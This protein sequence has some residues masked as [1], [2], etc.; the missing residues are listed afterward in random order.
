MEALAYLGLYLFYVFFAF[1]PQ[2][3]TIFLLRV[4]WKIKEKTLVSI[5]N[6]IVVIVILSPLF[7]LNWWRLLEWWG[8][9]HMIFIVITLMLVIPDIIRCFK[10]KK[11]GEAV[12]SSDINRIIIASLFIIVLMIVSFHTAKIDHFHLQEKI[13]RQQQNSQ[14]YNTALVNPAQQSNS[15]SSLTGIEYST[16]CEYFTLQQTLKNSNISND[17]YN[18]F[19]T[20]YWITITPDNIAQYGKTIQWINPKTMEVLW[21]N[22]FSHIKDQGKIYSLKANGFLIDIDVDSFEFLTGN[23][24]YAKDKN[25]IYYFSPQKELNYRMVPTHLDVDTFELITWSNAMFA[26]DKNNIYYLNRRDYPY[27]LEVK[28]NLN[29]IT[30]QEMINLRQEKEKRIN[31][32]F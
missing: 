15:C 3:I 31:M 28:E 6:I 2:I 26:K 10:K 29:T 16:D 30:L 5:L 12:T 18:R 14:L 19:K 4:L 23:T 20:V 8:I 25:H 32:P 17:A 9:W 1:V 13:Q 7:L 21:W 24:S 11:N 27:D 22:D